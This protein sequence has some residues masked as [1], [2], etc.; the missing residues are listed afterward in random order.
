MADSVTTHAV[1][2]FDGSDYKE[3][4]NNLMVVLMDKGWWG[5]SSGAV[6]RPDRLDYGGAAG[7][8]AEY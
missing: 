8:D 1:K 4:A 7:A 5:H 6:L 3:W 2:K